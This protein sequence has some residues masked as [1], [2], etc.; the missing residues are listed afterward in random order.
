MKAILRVGVVA[1]AALLSASSASACPLCHTE[2]GVKVRAGIFGD[3]F[4]RNVFVTLLPF[5]VLAG[6]VALIHF[7]FPN[8]KPLQSAG[9]GPSDFERT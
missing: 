8:P 6:I 9:A 4:G 1:G 2:T 3:E 5:P 7:G